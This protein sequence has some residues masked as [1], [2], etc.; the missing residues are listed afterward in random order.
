MPKDPICGMD[1]DVS[2]A[3]KGEK[4][5]QTFYFCSQHCK[6]KFLSKDNMEMGHKMHKGHEHHGKGGRA[7]HHAHMIAGFKKRFWISLIATIPV[8]ILSPLIQTFLGYKID[9]TGSMFVLLGISSFIYFYGGWPFLK[10]IFDE[11]KKKQPGMM[12]LIALA[13]SVAY[14]YSA[15]VV[16]G[17]KGKVFFWELVTLIDIMLLGH[18]IE[19]RSVMGASRALK[20]LAK[21]MPQEAHL[22]NGDGSIK[23]MKIEEIER[24]NKVLVKPGEKIPV[25]GKVVDGESEVNEAMLTGES[26][27]IDKR[28]GDKVMSGAVNGNGSLTVQVEKTGKDSYLSKVVELVRNELPLF[29]G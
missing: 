20:G 15:S 18:W 24:G 9:F 2:K 1:V 12:T 11:L 21:L 27:P 5:G 16:L 17:I 8:L 28:K 14:F 7:A 19:M 4:D 6:D 25:D 29:S 26:K 3:L 22:V 10:G 23:D 13:I